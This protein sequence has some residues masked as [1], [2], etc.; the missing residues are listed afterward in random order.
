MT[1]AISRTLPAMT[2]VQAVTAMGT[3]AL[4]VLAP[5]LGV[6]LSA[7]GVLGS[8]L[9]GIGALS[10]LA[11]GRMIRRFGDLP[12]A[13][14][15][16]AAVLLAMLCL[17]GGA[18]A[19]GLSPWSLWP[20][21]LLLGLAFG[22]ETPACASVLARVT[23]L[24]RRPWI[25]SIRQT[26]NQIGAMAG[27]LALPLL[28]VQHAALPFVLVAVIALVVGLWCLR[29]VTSD[30]GAP[31][32]ASAP[33]DA[34]GLRELS[35]SPALRL[36]TL[37]LVVFMATQVCLNFFVMSHAVRHWQL[38]V[39]QAAAWVALMQGAGL[40]GRLLWGRV[41]QRPGVVTARLLGALGLLIASAGLVLFLWPGTPPAVALTVLF[42]LVGI[43]ASGWN[44][45]MMAEIARIAGPARAGAVTGAALMFGYAGLALAPMLF[46]AAGS[47]W[48]TAMT[49]A[50]MLVMTGVMGICLLLRSG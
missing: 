36:L 19:G 37:T 28:L 48:G 12:L 11:T 1:S 18:L 15:C 44:G 14:M 4:S 26:G 46:A 47:V 50:G 32:L 16:M 40:I 9:F 25:F 24:A 38:P 10:S 3:F 27:S 23:P 7:L 33:G 17:A 13:A 29:L 22:P 5:Q 39:P 31:T 43:S 8:V 41:A 34:S 6:G 45:V 42:V 49:Y 20:A 2:A 30:G 21:V 35:G